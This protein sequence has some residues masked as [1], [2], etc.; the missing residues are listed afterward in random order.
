MWKEELPKTYNPKAIEDRWYEYW[1]RI[2]A[3]KAEVQPGKPRFSMVIPPPNVTG[4]LHMGHALNNA[5]QDVLARWKRMQGYNTLWIPGTDHAGIATQIK[6]E[7]RLREEE[8]KSRYDLG[9]EAFIDRVWAWK[10]QYRNNIVGQLKKLGAS[11]DWSKERFTMDEGCS[12]AVR[13]VFV[14]LFEK[15]LIYQGSYIVHW[16]PD[17]RT[18]LSDLEVD[19]EETEG[20]LWH[21]KYPF[22]DGRGYAVV[23]TTRPET[24][25]GDTAVAVSPNDDRYQDL[26]GKKVVL[27]ILKREIPI[28]ADDFVDPAFGTGM[29]KVT[30]AHD[31][32]DFEIGHRHNLPQITVIDLAG[33]MNE[34]AGPYQGMDRYEC[35]KQ[36]VKDLEEA[37]LLVKMESHTHAVGHCY[38][39]HNVIEPLLSK[40]WF[41]KMKPL[42]EPA[43]KTVQEGKINFL[44]ERF[45]KNYLH[46]MENIRDWCI[47]R[48]L[49]WGHRIPVFTCNS[50]QHVWASEV[51]PQDCVKCHSTDIK[52]DPD[53][54]DTWFSSALW[55][56]STLGWPDETEELSYF[57]PTDVLVTA[58]DI[59]YFWVARMIFM[60]LEMKKEIPFEHVVIHGIIRDSLGRKMSKSL[61]NGV[62]PLEVIEEYGADALRITLL[63]GTAPGNDLRYYEE[64]VEASRN[65]ANKIW[66]ASRFAL[67][68]L[69]D[70]DHSLQDLV[71]LDLELPDRWILSRYT[72]TAK[73]VTRHLERFDFGEGARASYDFIWSELCD[74]Y[75]ELIKPR[76]YGHYGDES[77]K[78]AQQVLCHVLTHTIELLHPYM[79]FITEEIWQHLPHDGETVMKAPW[80]VPDER[81]LDKEAEEDISLVMDVI[82]G[83]RNIRAEKNVPPSKEVPA[84]VMIEK[85]KMSVLEKTKGL[86]NSLARLSRMDITEAGGPIPEKAAANVVG[87]VAV[88]LPLTG[89]VDIQKERARLTEELAKATSMLEKT[90]QR[91]ANES[92][93]SKAPPEVIEGAKKQYENLS[94][95]VEKV[96]RL[97]A[98]L[99]DEK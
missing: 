54:L 76:L 56:F 71:S 75:V 68:N 67:M 53:V 49:W 58:W 61:G 80:P 39:C 83:V 62:D 8:G 79:P 3:F 29:V 92:F 7:A 69:T 77:R 15:G 6:V 65:F 18:T 66:N 81:L 99:A 55:P 72:Q 2:N 37:G 32:N 43:I 91:L 28:V 22:A 59:I 45:K 46:W 11:C 73:E 94:L 25:L 50:C 1:E 95:Q 60:S 70:Y 63:T 23:A 52:Q 12:R 14:E 17:C 40:Q 30:P 96:Q 48:Q 4:A 13:K 24:M 20:N 26:I 78:V 82:K 35:R 97:L 42:A 38:R 27:P 90:A 51:D 88:Y 87:Q 33:K 21:I 85:D 74:W 9:R 86:I 84:I 41:V 16:C 93:L 89:L 31:P 34:Q 36:L 57:F 64:K 19:H 10:E 98:E 44:P 47:S 5:L